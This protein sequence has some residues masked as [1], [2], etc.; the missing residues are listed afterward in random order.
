[1]REHEVPAAKRFAL[2]HR[3][4]VARAFGGAAPARQALLRARLLSFY[5]A[6]QSTPFPADIVALFASAPEFVQ[7]VGCGWGYLRGLSRVCSGL[8]L[9]RP[10][11]CCW[12]V[13]SQAL[14]AEL[15]PCTPPLCLPQLA[16]LLQREGEGVPDDVQTLA[17]RALAVQLLDR[18][19][20]GAVIA[21]IAGGEQSGLL[22]LLI[23]RAV[24]SLTGRE[25]VPRPY[26]QPFIEAL[27]SMLGALV[28]STAGTAALADASLVP[29]L[30]PL[31]EHREPA[32]LALVASTV[33][34][35]EAFMDFR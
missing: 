13:V 26:S 25:P 6:F 14:Q 5:I 29:A 10:S 27:L 33:R 22:A 1:M 30:L 3:I 20:H 34:I 7:Q 21:A 9:L 35:L 23:H 17:L 4:R 31:L 11:C 19:R 2:L 24:A 32:H 8:S 15:T 12:R 28:T 16:A 18:S